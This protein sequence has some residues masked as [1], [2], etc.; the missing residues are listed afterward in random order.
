VNW[1][2]TEYDDWLSEQYMSTA[3]DSLQCGEISLL[4][5]QLGL[6]IFSKTMHLNCHYGNILSALLLD[7]QTHD[8][9]KQQ[10]SVLEI[11]ILEFLS[12]YRF[13]S[14]IFILKITTDLFYVIWRMKNNT[15]SL[16]TSEFASGRAE[17][18]AGTNLSK[19][20]I[21]RIIYNVTA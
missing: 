2:K 21:N 1:L 7:V 19:P 16:P 4:A 10:I 5:Q 12:K 18:L 6:S 8:I 17:F 11:P 20:K 13:L 14:A 15:G 3:F 9:R